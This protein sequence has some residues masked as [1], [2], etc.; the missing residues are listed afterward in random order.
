MAPLL[1]PDMVALIERRL[2]AVR[3]R[4]IK[5]DPIL[6]PAS[7]IVSR[8]G[9]LPKIDGDIIHHGIIDAVRAWTDLTVLPEWR[10]PISDSADRLAGAGR[11]DQCLVTDLPFDNRVVDTVQ[12]D[13]VTINAVTGEATAYEVKRGHGEHDSGKRQKIIDDLMRVRLVLAGHLR[14]CGHTEVR[15]AAVRLVSYYGSGTTGPIKTLTR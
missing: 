4:K 3:R 2:A 15:T 6:G 13:L 9:S 11:H 14:E 12:V 5:V 8:L 10:T 1:T 7:G